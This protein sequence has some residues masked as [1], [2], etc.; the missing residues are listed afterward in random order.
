M[1][2]QTTKL[3]FSQLSEEQDPDQINWISVSNA[4]QVFTSLKKKNLVDT[5]I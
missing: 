3:I 1:E 5:G 2:E 4:T